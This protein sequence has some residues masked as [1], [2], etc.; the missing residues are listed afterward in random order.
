MFNFW[1]SRKLSGKPGADIERINIISV[2]LN[3]SRMSLSYT[4]WRYLIIQTFRRFP[5]YLMKIR[6]P[7]PPL[8]QPDQSIPGCHLNLISV[9]DVSF[10][11]E[12]ATTTHRKHSRLFT[13]KCSTPLELSHNA[14][15]IAQG[16]KKGTEDTQVMDLIWHLAMLLIFRQNNLLNDPLYQIGGS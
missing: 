4:C 14:S 1:Q 2:L 6:K 12:A 10:L 5:I 3:A 8:F 11:N 13:Q 7:K 9:Q 15:R 16:Q